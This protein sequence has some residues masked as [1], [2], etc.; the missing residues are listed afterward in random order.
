MAEGC[1]GVAAG[2]RQGGAQALQVAEHRLRQ[3]AGRRRRGGELVGDAVEGSLAH[4]A[5][6]RA[7]DAR[8]AG[9]RRV[10]RC[11]RRRVRR[12]VRR[13]VRRCVREGCRAQ[14][15]GRGCEEV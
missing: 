2:R 11:V 14:G 6:R 12:C 1:G 15:Q 9:G 5:E 13:R 10:R 7:P 4:P 8:R 3:L